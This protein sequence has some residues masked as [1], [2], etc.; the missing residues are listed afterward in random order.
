MRRLMERELQVDDAP[1][2]VSSDNMRG[3]AVQGADGRS[4]GHVDHVMIDKRAGRLA[5]VVLAYGSALGIGE[6]LYPLP[7]EA[8]A[9][10]RS[11]DG[12]RAVVTRDD[13]EGAP[14]SLA[15]EGRWSD[16]NWRSKIDAHFAI[17][18]QGQ[19]AHA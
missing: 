6:R 5:Y 19:R 2:L 18:R 15:D 3:V 8:L 11:I 16:P 7:Y 10:D 14:H 13:V 12:Y 9:Y 4:L 1:M 17:P